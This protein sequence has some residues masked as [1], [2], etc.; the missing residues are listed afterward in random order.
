M[1]NLVVCKSFGREKVEN[2]DVSGCLHFYIG[3]SSAQRPY[4]N[5]YNDLHT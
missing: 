5:P 4:I 1:Y 2:K 3:L